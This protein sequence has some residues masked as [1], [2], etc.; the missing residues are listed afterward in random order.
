M[1][2][3]FAAIFFSFL[4]LEQFTETMFLRIFHNLSS[5]GWGNHT[6]EVFCLLAAMPFGAFVII[7]SKGT[8]TATTQPTE[9]RFN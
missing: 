2:A 8:V 1:I 4:R 6:I 7:T 3:L 9:A 5:F